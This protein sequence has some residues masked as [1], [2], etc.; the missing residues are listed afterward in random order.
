MNVSVRNIDSTFESLAAITTETFSD[1]NN[2]Q[3]IS[4][5]VV[6]STLREN[7]V[8][9]TRRIL[10]PASRA[11]A[12]IDAAFSTSQATV[13]KNAPF[14]TFKPAFANDAAIV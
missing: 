9:E 5:V 2:S 14:R 1:F 12:T 8:S 7:V 11:R 3:I 10:K 13:S 4:S 6:S